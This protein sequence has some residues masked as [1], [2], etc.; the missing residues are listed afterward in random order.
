MNE[1]EFTST[2]HCA[3]CR[4]E[5][6]RVGAERVSVEVVFTL[7]CSK[8]QCEVDARTWKFLHNGISCPVC[9]QLIQIGKIELKRTLRPWHSEVGEEKVITV[10]RE[11]RWIYKMNTQFLNSFAA[12]NEESAS[13]SQALTPQ[14]IEKRIDYFDWGFEPSTSDAVSTQQRGR[15]AGM[16]DEEEDDEDDY[17]LQSLKEKFVKRRVMNLRGVSDEIIGR[18]KSNKFL[19]LHVEFSFRMQD[20][21]I[22]PVVVSLYGVREEGEHPMAMLDCQWIKHDETG[23]KRNWYTIST[24]GI[25]PEVHFENHLSGISIGAIQTLIS[26]YGKDKVI[27]HHGPNDM[28]ALGLNVDSAKQLLRENNIF[29]FDTTQVYRNATGLFSLKSL[30]KEFIKTDIQVSSHTPRNCPLQSS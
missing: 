14:N 1:F 11:D 28:Q 20:K 18:I 23:A 6:E 12:S 15:M 24:S 5:D 19:A 21:A 29:L 16:S 7:A 4:E 13:S 10:Q 3:N 8:C 30:A 27:V 26:L 25:T 22:H 2:T 17:N 9:C